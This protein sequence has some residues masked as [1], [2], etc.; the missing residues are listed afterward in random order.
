MTPKRPHI[1]FRRGVITILLGVG[2]YI[3]YSV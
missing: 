3:V 2:Y 1:V